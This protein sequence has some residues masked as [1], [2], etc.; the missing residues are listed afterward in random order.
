MRN[1]YSSLKFAVHCLSTDNVV[2]ASYQHA[3]LGSKVVAKPDSPRG[4]LL[5]DDMGLGKTLTMIS[6]IVMSLDEARAFTSSQ[7]PFNRDSG[8]PSLRRARSTLVIAPSAGKPFTPWA[9]AAILCLRS[10]VLLDGWDDEIKRFVRQF[11]LVWTRLTVLRRHVKPGLVEVLKYH[12]IGKQIDVDSMIKYDVIMTT[13]ATIAS[14]VSKRS[15]PLHQILW[16]RIILDEGMQF[17]SGGF[18]NRTL[19]HEVLSPYSTPPV[20][21]TVSSGL[22]SSSRATLGLECDAHSE[23]D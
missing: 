2:L 15:S 11:S 23:Q 3:I 19:K 21:A 20:Y 18:K 5:A 14:D 17:M 16:F 1:P 8:L 6:A 12:G 22:F 10:I 7:H 13:Y 9:Y 4:G